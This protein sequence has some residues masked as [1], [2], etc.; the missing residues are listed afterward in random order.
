[1]TDRDYGTAG[2]PNTSSL[3]P[4]IRDMLMHRYDAR[5]MNNIHRADYME[6][7]VAFTLGP[8]WSLPWVDGWDWAPWDCQHTSGARLEVKQSAARQ[9]W[10]R[11]AQAARRFPRFDI[12][13]RTGYWTRDGGQWIEVPGRPADLYVFAWHDEGRASCCDQ[14][15][16]GQWL[17]LVVA[18]QDLPVDRKR[19]GWADLQMIAPPCRIAGLKRAVETALPAKAA[20]K[21]TLKHA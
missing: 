9:S 4:R 7:L 5:V 17:F 6:C 1:M 14:R 19:I 12:A 21:A 8:G 11:E 10:D 2:D 13:P 20:L 16:A 3:H 18:E 15:D